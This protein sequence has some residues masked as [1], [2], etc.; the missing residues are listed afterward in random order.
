MYHRGHLLDERYPHPP[1]RFQAHGLG[2]DTAQEPW[3]SGGWCSV[4]KGGSSEDKTGKTN[5]KNDL[6]AFRANCVRVISTFNVPGE[7]MARACKWIH[8]LDAGIHGTGPDAR[9]RQDGDCPCEMLC[10]E[11]QDVSTPLMSSKTAANCL[12]ASLPTATRRSW[13]AYK[14]VF[15]AQALAPVLSGW[16]PFFKTN[17]DLKKLLTL[18]IIG[19]LETDRKGKATPFAAHTKHNKHNYQL[20]LAAK[21]KADYT[22]ASRTST[23]MPSTSSPRSTT[24]LV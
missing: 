22:A 1:H 16:V 3:H 13:G 2:H 9:M 12:P 14:Q 15:D 7:A 5:A 8:H 6:K 24:A 4:D 20:R 19:I 21:K 10:Q 23:R 11:L 17:A 18:S